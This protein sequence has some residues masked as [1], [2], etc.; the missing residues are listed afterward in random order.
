VQDG[1]DGG[2]KRD[3]VH[4]WKGERIRGGRTIWVNI[5]EKKKKNGG[6][7][8]NVEPQAEPSSQESMQELKYRTDVLREA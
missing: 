8:E 2:S 1:V 4:E 7:R 3:E 6:K 5:S